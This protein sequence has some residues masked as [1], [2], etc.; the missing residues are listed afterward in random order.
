[1]SKEDCKVCVVCGL[2]QE[3][4]KTN[5]HVFGIQIGCSWNAIKDYK[6]GIKDTRKKVS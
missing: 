1:M 3:Q 5:M 4:H 2:T 6:L